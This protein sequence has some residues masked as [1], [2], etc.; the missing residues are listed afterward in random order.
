MLKPTFL[1]P[2]VPK[3]TLAVFSLVTRHKRPTRNAASGLGL[4]FSVLVGLLLT[5]VAVAA[6][7]VAPPPPFSEQ[8]RATISSHFSALKQEQQ[9][10]AQYHQTGKKNGNK[11]LPPGL[12]KKAASGHLPP[13]WKKQLKIGAVLPP[14]VMAQAERLPP[15][16]LAQLPAGPAGTLTVAV[17]GEIIRV[18]E[19]SRTIVDFISTAN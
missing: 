14:D 5:P 1:R 18:I 3:L 16:L 11:A 4:V 15:K 2:T 6:E 12:D 10:I 8:E 17:D 13:G 7:K 19:A 9:L